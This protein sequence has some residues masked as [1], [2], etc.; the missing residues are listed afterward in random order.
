[1]EYE[2]LGTGILN[3]LTGLWQMFVFLALP[4]TCAEVMADV[5][6]RSF[7][8][9]MWAWWHLGMCAF[10]HTMGFSSKKI[11]KVLEICF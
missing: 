4:G 6:L 11:E 8:V 7:T 5:M 3:S 9:G 1:M 10:Q 2:V